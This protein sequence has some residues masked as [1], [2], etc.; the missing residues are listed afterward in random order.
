MY[1]L[2]NL[3]DSGINYN[4]PM[5]FEVE[6][7]LDKERLERSFEKLITRHE[8]LRTSFEI[9]GEEIIQKIH[10]EVNFKIS[11]Q[12]VAGEESIREKIN[13]FIIPFDL[14]KTPPIKG[15]GIKDIIRKTYNT[16]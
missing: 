12:E 2:G 6:G 16:Y 3:K 1:I 4:I 13:K 14:K 8:S 7:K 9:H 10:K 11:Y 5:P 15:S